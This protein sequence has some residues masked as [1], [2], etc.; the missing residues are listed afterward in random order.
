MSL[1]SPRS[2]NRQDSI[3]MREPNGSTDLADLLSMPGY[4]I[5]RSKQ[6]TTSAFADACR[7]FAITPVQFA[8][9]S[10]LNARPGVDQTEF[11]ELAGLDASTTGD[12]I[13]RLEKRG[14]LSRSEDGNRRICNLTP[15]G[16]DVLDQLRPVVAAAQTRVLAPLTGREQAQLLRLLSKLNGVSNRHYTSPPD[17]RLRR[18]AKSNP[19]AKS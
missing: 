14:L 10:I 12:V 5:R 1:T 15:D 9:M 6:I 11:G 7:E 8:A 4:L 17:R 19:L 18:R 2:P 13:Q 16:C 3:A